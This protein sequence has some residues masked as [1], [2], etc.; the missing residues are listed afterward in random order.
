MKTA[1]QLERYFKGAANHN[2][3]KILSLLSKTDG[4]S[5]EDIADK[6]NGNFKTISEH[7]RRLV[8]AGLL[9]KRQ[10]GRCVEHFLSPYG[11]LFADFAKRF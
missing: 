5:L 2:R 4:L 11:K 10:A 9:N 1:K 7:T 3:L 8:Q 6:L